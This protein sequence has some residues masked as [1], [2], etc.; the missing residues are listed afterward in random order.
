MT[1][2]IIPCASITRLPVFAVNEVTPIVSVS[3]EP[4][5]DPLDNDTPLLVIT[6]VIFL[7]EV[8]DTTLPPDAI[9]GLYPRV[10]GVFLQSCEFVS[11]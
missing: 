3:P 5:L 9:T 4:Q 11:M 10:R 7:P 8:S 2:I 1:A 6:A